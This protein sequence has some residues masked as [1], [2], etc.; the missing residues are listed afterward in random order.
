[1]QLSATP[2]LIGFV[3]PYEV[4]EGGAFAPATFDYL[5]AVAQQALDADDPGLSPVLYD[6]AHALLICHLFEARAGNLEKTAETIADYRYQKGPGTTTYL[7]EYQK[8]LAANR[9]PPVPSSGVRRGD[10]VMPGLQLDANP[11]PEHPPEGLL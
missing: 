11:L 10:V 5:S 9:V 2:D 1:M 4:V 6:H 8:I 7:I 3:S